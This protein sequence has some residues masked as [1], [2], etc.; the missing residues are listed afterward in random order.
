MSTDV[1]KEKLFQT[2]FGEELEHKPRE[3]KVQDTL[4][5]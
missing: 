1:G 3:G 2:A 5:N 4:D